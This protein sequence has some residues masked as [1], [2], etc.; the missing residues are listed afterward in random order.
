MMKQKNG[1]FVFVS[2]EDGDERSWRK[3]KS[4]LSIGSIFR[5]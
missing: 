2:L 1:W 3:G 4:D 5:V